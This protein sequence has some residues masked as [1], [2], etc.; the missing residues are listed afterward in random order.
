MPSTRP[1]S[2]STK[3]PTMA[4]LPKDPSAP[5]R[6]PGQRLSKAELSRHERELRAQRLFL[7]AIAA[8]AVV[9][10]AILGF[11]YWREYVARASDP[12]ATVA[13][14]SI[15]VDSYARQLD[16]N[17]K[18]VEQQIQYM[19]VQLQSFSD[20]ESLV[21]LI[22]QQIQQLQFS[23]LLLPDQTLDQMIN[24]ELV[25][26]EAARRGITVSAQ[27]IEEETKQTFQDPPTPLPV[28]SPTPDPTAAAGAQ[29][30]PTPEASPT[31]TAPAASPMPTADIQARAQAFMAMYGLTQAEYDSMIE[32][33]ILYKKLGEAIGAEVPTSADQIHARHILVDSE[34]KAK[35]LVEK[36]RGGASFEELAKAE[37]TDP[38]SKD[39]GGDL[40]WFPRGTMVP[41]FD[42][43][44]FKLEPKQISDPVQTTY[45]WHI[46]EVLEKEQNRPL[47]EQTLESKKSE[48]LPQWLSEKQNGPDVKRALTEDT[49][50]WVYQRIK[51]RPPQ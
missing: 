47:D 38:G 27:E 26:Q 13:G 25:R 37:S 31:P 33:Q 46:I 4:R 51:W 19:Q 2:T 3:R 40:G 44:A 8:L 50:N 29:P 16:F 23:L 17:R 36:L 35:E 45:G 32:A 24:E 22:R 49:K 21:G 41:E 9:V 30:T 5:R 6:I 42:D 1:D 12:V 20:D 28:P 48:A 43:V 34:D 7:V 14:H 11:G 39:K 15:S 10:V 18:T